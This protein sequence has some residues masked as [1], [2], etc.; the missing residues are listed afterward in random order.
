M[1]HNHQQQQNLNI[2]ILSTIE[3][4]EREK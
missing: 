1:Y 2:E 4:R 3:R